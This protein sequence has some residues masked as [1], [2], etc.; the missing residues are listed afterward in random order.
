MTFEEF[1][2][3]V[4]EELKQESEIITCNRGEYFIIKNYVIN[5]GEFTGKIVNIGI[6]YV[7]N[8][9]FTPELSIHINPCISS[10]GIKMSKNGKYRIRNVLESSNSLGHDWQYWSIRFDKPVS[11]P[12]DYWNQIFNMLLGD[13]YDEL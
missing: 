1:I 12:R 7:R 11:T 3:F 5:S 10:L 8:N 4:K 6:K 13:V 9:P 2:I